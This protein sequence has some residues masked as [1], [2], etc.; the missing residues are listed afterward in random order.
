[1]HLPLIGGTASPEAIDQ[2][3]NVF[4][5]EATPLGNAGGSAPA[6][7]AVVDAVC[8]HTGMT[9]AQLAGRSRNREVSYARHLAMYVLKHDAHKAVSEIQRLFGNRDH[10]TVIGAI[11]RIEGEL[12]TRPETAADLASVRQTLAAPPAPS[13]AEATPSPAP[14]TRLRVAANT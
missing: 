2:A 1:M 13:L 3:L 8:A 11:D 6:A 7:D 9:A 5:V 10:S 14:V 4:D 12:A